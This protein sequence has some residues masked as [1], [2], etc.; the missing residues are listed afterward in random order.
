MADPVNNEPAVNEEKED[1][2]HESDSP[3]AAQDRK[4][5][6]N[7]KKYERKKKAK[8]SKPKSEDP[9]TRIDSIAGGQGPICLDPTAASSFDA[10]GFTDEN[11]MPVLPSDRPDV[12]EFKDTP[13]GRGTG[14][15]ATRNIAKGERIMEETP[16]VIDRTVSE[17]TQTCGNR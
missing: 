7:Q 8:K 15:Y 17:R 2:K 12:Y 9:V 5:R 6:R 16:L 4:E 13:D 11:I 1:T 10:L 3:Q 14:V